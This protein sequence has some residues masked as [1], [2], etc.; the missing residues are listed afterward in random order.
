MLR[1]IR[2]RKLLESLIVGALGGLLSGGLLLFAQEH[3]NAPRL[4]MNWAQASSPQLWRLE[5]SNNGRT[6]LNN[7]IVQIICDH[8]ILYASFPPGCM[9][10]DGLIDSTSDYMIG[11]SKA[12]FTILSLPPDTTMSIAIA[13][14]AASTKPPES[15]IL[16]PV[17]IRSR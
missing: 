12:T 16:G 1:A 2:T 3:R 6:S 4:Q 8:P 9:D 17:A 13:L 14:R 7:V 15:L 11:R 10:A 5:I